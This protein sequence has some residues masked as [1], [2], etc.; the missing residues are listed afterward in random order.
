MQS[1]S[2][3]SIGSQVKLT[4]FMFSASFT[5]GC[6]MM[7]GWMGNP[8]ENQKNEIVFAQA[9]EVTVLGKESVAKASGDSMPVEDKPV[10]I[11]APGYVGVVVVPT[12]TENGKIRVAL[13][14][15]EKW[16]T[17]GEKSRNQQQNNK[18]VSE[19][20]EG[21]SQ[22]QR[23]LIENRGEDALVEVTNLSNR[24]P[25]ISY[26]NFMRASCLVVIGKQELALEVLE[27]ALKDFPDNNSGKQLYKS[28]TGNEYLAH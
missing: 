6:A 16:T 20:I 27:A 7:S 19:I 10:Y 1:H 12:S 8:S 2:Q 23:L 4:I 18:V 28:L 9:V 24:Y 26:L 17:T 25:N 22:V 5:T 21:V 3:K 14:P 13:K 11:E 15:A